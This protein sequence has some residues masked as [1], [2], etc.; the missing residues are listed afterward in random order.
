[1]KKKFYKNH[2]RIIK[3]LSKIKLELENEDMDI[4][5]D[6]LI[7]SNLKQ[8]IEDKTLLNKIKSI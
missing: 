6:R 7:E 2:K 8:E 5:I 3:E 1:M 4:L